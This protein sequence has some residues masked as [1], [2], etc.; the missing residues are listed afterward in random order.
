MVVQRALTCW[1]LD[2]RC[3]QYRRSSARRLRD[4]VCSVDAM[5]GTVAWCL[6]LMHWRPDRRDARHLTMSDVGRMPSSIIRQRD[7]R[8]SGTP[9]TPTFFASDGAERIIFS[10]MPSKCHVEQVTAG[11]WQAGR[12]RI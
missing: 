5:A 8:G 10:R 4:A 12:C 1:L 9:T 6:R 2:R 3:Y 11:V 7:P